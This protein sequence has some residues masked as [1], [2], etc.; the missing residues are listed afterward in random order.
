MK[1]DSPPM[2]ER[3]VRGDHDITLQADA[4]TLLFSTAAAGDFADPTERDTE[5]LEE[6]S[7]VKRER[8]AQDQQVHGTEVRVVDDAARSAAWSAPVDAQL[9]TAPGVLCLVRVAD[10]VPVLLAGSQ[11]VGAVHAGWKGLHGGII[12]NAVT[13]LRLRG[14][15]PLTAAIGPCARGCCYEVGED[16][17]DLF[18]GVPQAARSGHRLDLADIAKAQLAALQVADVVDTGLCTICSEPDEFFSYRRDGGEAGRM[19]GAA[20]LN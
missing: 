2:S 6:L 16:T 12:A 14:A 18:S 10:C 9:T 5:W 1:D 4:A 13:A 3:F 17:L 8:W 20:W 7:S 11:G 15:P 19:I